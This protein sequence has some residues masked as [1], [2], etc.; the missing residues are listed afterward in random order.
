MLCGFR[1]VF[2]KNR[3]S[4]KMCASQYLS[5]RSC[6]G[7]EI[8]DAG[9][10]NRSG[11]HLRNQQSLV[12]CLPLFTAMIITIS[13]R[14]APAEAERRWG[15]AEAHPVAEAASCQGPERCLIFCLYSLGQRGGWVG[16]GA[17]QKKP[18]YTLPST[19]REIATLQPHP[20]RAVRAAPS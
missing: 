11:P 17:L 13:L 16:G 12:H 1:V 15:S 18:W 3:G 14:K 2:R 4:I 8:V 6:D 20:S 9:R 19:V 7:G 10:S 5:Y